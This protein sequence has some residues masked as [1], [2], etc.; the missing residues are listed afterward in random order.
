MN[1]PENEKNK[2]LKIFYDPEQGLSNAND[3]YKKLN[4]SIT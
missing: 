2:I 1:I 4:K 3:I